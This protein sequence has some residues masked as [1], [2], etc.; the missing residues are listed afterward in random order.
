MYIYRNMN[1][2]SFCLHEFHEFYLLYSINFVRNLYKK[3]EISEEATY[4]PFELPRETFEYI[5]SKLGPEDILALFNIDSKFNYYMTHHFHPNPHEIINSI[6]YFT[7]NLTA[8][9]APYNKIDYRSTI[10]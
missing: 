5:V 1:F 10:N 2:F 6:F 3:E 9:R 7:S 4:I 8:K